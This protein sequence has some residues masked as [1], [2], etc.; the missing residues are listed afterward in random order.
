[1]ATAVGIPLRYKEEKLE[2]GERK[3]QRGREVS[4]SMTSI[5]AVI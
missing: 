2:D 1:M 3:R 5:D 4:Y